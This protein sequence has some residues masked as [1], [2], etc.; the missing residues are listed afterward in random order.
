MTLPG[1]LRRRMLLPLLLTLGILPLLTLCAPSARNESAADIVAA[2]TDTLY[3]PRFASRFI[4]IS[5]PDSARRVVSTLRPWQGAGDVATRLLLLPEGERASSSDGNLK[6][7]SGTPRRIICMS[8]THVA[9]LDALGATD[10]IVGV[11]GLQYIT[12]PSLLSRKESAPVD[13]GFDGNIDYESLAGARPD[14]VLLSAATGRSE[15]EGKLDEL[16]IPYMYVGDYTE[17][18]PLGKSEWVVAL[19]EV[20]G[21]RERGCEVIDSLAPLYTRWQMVAKEASAVPKVLFNAPYSDAWM[22]PPDDSYMVRLVIDAGGVPVKGNPSDAARPVDM[23]E[24]YRLASQADVWLN[25]GQAS[26]LSTLSAM[27]P[28]LKGSPLMSEG[29]V[30]NNN[31]L[32]IPG[33]GNPYFERGVMQP[34]VVL[35]DLVTIFHPYL[36]PGRATVYYHPLK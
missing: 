15:M 7:L 1:N 18:G 23:E 27:A 10:R 33:G 13:V 28:R 26:D 19:G 35:A 6:V 9:M 25:P 5:S 20:L 29:K 31:R 3:S 30:F 22:L 34:D 21:L 32:A 14:L 36:A 4:I 8:S 12:T 2:L 11:S 24:A 17:S 16:G